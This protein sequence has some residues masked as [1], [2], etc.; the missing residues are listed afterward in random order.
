[1]V[2]DT[3]TCAELL[4]SCLRRYNQCHDLVLGER[5]DAI[6][7]KLPRLAGFP[8]DLKDNYS[9]PLHTAS[10]DL[11]PDIVWW[12]DNPKKL[13]LVELAVPL[14]RDSKI[15]QREKKKNPAMKT[16]STAQSRQAMILTSSQL[17]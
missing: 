14:R 7:Q 8:V 11:R 10:T 9:F 12:E 13:R 6:T 1:L 17:R 15:R 3:H 5:A 4:Q 16:W 2:A